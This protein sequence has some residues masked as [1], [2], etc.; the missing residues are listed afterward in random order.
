MHDRKP[1]GRNREISGFLCLNSKTENQLAE[2]G[3]GHKWQKARAKY[4]SENPF[5][6]DHRKL[7][8]DVLA[9]VVDHIVPHN[10]DQKLF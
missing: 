3:Y 7:G 5:C 1:I 6:V 8:R 9:T 2:R 10:G 4:L